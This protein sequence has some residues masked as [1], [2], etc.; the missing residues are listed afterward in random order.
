MAENRTQ[1][2][3]LLKKLED[4]KEKLKEAEQKQ[5]SAH[6]D[7]EKNSALQDQRINFLER[8]MKGL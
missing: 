4:E 2:V 7:R 8:D 1:E 3:L 5:R 6:K